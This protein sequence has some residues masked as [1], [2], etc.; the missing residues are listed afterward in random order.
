MLSRYHPAIHI[1]DLDMPTDSNLMYMVATELWRSSPH[2]DII[3]PALPGNPLQGVPQE[4]VFNTY[5]EANLPSFAVTDIDID[6][7]NTI[8]NRTHFVVKLC[9]A[10]ARQDMYV[11]GFNYPGMLPFPDVRPL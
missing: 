9:D 11:K 8:T 2:N 10:A 4:N 1:I 6:F 5:L 7:V 3:H